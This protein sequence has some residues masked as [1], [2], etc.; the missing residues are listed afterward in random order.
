[1]LPLYKNL[2]DKALRDLVIE[3]GLDCL[4]E[5]PQ[6]NRDDL[7]R[8]HKEFIFTLQAAHDAVRMGM[9]PGETVPTKPGLAKAFSMEFRVK[10]GAKKN[11]LL[12]AQV[13]EVTRRRA[14]ADKTEAIADL[15]TEA[16]R[17]MMNQLRNALRN[18][19]PPPQEE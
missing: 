15:T 17:R 13:A 10:S 19:K 14:E 6:M 4:V 5:N 1:M 7:I 3:D 8:H 9:Y 11:G 2:K 18:R 16:S 12:G